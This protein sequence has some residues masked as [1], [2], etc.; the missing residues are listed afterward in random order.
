MLKKIKQGA[1]GLI[2]TVIGLFLLVSSVGIKNNPIKQEGWAGVFSQAKFIPIIASA[3]ITI[4]GF[5]LFLRQIKGT[6]NSVS[7]PKAELIRMLIVLAMSAAYIIACY[8]F[9][10]MIPT[11]VFAIAIFTFLNL[12]ERKPLHIAFFIVLAIVLGLWGMPFMI[13]LKLPMT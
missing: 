3:G 1:E 12:K 10:F 2:V 8:F 6:K 13:N 9:K 11:I 7:M 5:A 4:L